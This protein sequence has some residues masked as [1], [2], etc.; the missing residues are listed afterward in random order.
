MLST[1]IIIRN[2]WINEQIE[3]HGSTRNEVTTVYLE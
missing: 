3:K 1:N 2:R